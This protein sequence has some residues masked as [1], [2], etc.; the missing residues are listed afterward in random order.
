MDDEPLI[1]WSVSETLK[2][3]GFQVVLRS[4][5]QGAFNAVSQSSD[6]FDAVLLDLRL[7]DSA[8]L[9]LLQALRRLVPRAAFILMTAH[10][11]PELALEAVGY[12]ADFVLDKP[13]ELADLTRVVAGALASRQSE[14]GIFTSSAN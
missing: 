14:P 1:R 3:S 9:S 12:G 2:D 6:P 13:F 8:D 11:S 4:D 10:N 7:P 5:A